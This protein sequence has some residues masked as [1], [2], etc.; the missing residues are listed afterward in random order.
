VYA[1]DRRQVSHVWVAG[2]Q[3][4]DD[5]QLTTLNAHHLQQLAVDWAARIKP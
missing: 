2:R 5:R 3:L 4:L 1:C